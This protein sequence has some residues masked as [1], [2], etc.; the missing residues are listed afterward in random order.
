MF[1][2]DSVLASLW[3]S[4]RRRARECLEAQISVSAACVAIEGRRIERRGR[5]TACLPRMHTARRSM[6]SGGSLAYLHHALMPVP[7]LTSVHIRTCRSTHPNP[8]GRLELAIEVWLCLFLSACKRIFCAYMY[9]DNITGMST[10]WIASCA[11]SYLAIN[12]VSL[13]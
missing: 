5:R 8:H 1:M 9:R 10:T 7:T 13:D 2:H 4:K 11:A 12:K 6:S 3:T